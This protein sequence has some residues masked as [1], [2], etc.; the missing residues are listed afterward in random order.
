MTFGRKGFFGYSVC[1]PLPDN[2]PVAPSE[3]ATN[4]TPFIMWWS[5]YEVATPPSR[6][7]RVSHEKIKKQLLARHGD[8]KSPYDSEAGS[9][10]KQLIELGCRSESSTSDLDSQV[11][12][13]VQNA[14]LGFDTSVL[15]LPRYVT[16]RLPFWSNATSPVA[17]TS[18]CGRGRIVLIGDAAHT[19]PPDSGQGASCAIEDAVVYSLLLKHFLSIAPSTSSLD[20]L[21]TPLDRAAKAYEKL[22]KPRVHQILDFAK[23]TGDA[24][25]EMGWFAQMVR[26]FAISILCKFSSKRH[27]SFCHF[28]FFR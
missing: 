16:P 23:R 15:L 20:L 17:E 6:K 22:R 10:Y 3:S 1:T 28:L 2:L 12:G 13:R 4:A 27:V 5:T 11:T 7:E 8:W 14:K 9:V 26:D 21:G 18:P 19:M 24:K 25:K